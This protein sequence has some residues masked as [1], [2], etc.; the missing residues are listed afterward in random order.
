MKTKLVYN[1]SKDDFDVYVDGELLTGPKLAAYKRRDEKIKRANLEEMVRTGKTPRSI[2][3]D[4][5]LGTRG[6]LA[7]QFDGDPDVFKQVVANAQRAG[8]TPGANDVYLS[9]LA[10]FP[11]DPKAF[12]SRSRGGRGRVA[13]ILNEKGV[14]D[15]SGS[16]K[17]KGRQDAPAPAVK[18]GTDLVEK[19]VNQMIKKNPELK[20][21]D[22]RDLRAE[23]IAKH[24]PKGA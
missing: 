15:I 10:D 22:R 9:Q 14:A 19:N 2:T 17:A 6:T 3:N 4:S 13:E 8:Y 1:R 20:R 16:V 18:L 5:F 7:S 24:G 23:A 12:I 21:V 11:G